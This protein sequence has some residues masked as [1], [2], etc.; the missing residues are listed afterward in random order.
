MMFCLE[1]KSIETAE[2][3]S[4]LTDKPLRAGVNHFLSPNLGTILGTTVVLPGRGIVHDRNALKN[5][6]R[7]Y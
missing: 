6:S 1:H 4:H 2:T 3:Y 5:L 7:D